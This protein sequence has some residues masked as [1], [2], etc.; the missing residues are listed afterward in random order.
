M[1][2]EDRVVSRLYSRLEKLYG[3]R[4][5]GV[6][7]RLLDVLY[8][9]PMNPHPVPASR[10]DERDIVLITYGDQLRQGD[11]PTLPVLGSFLQETELDRLINTIHIL[12]FYPYSSDDG[13]S[14]IDYRRVDPAIGDWTDVTRLG[15]QT[16]LMFDLVLNHTS[17]ESDWFRAYRAGEEPYTRF[18]I[19]SEPDVDWSQVT[20]PRNTP[21]LTPQQTTR[22]PRY[23]W[24]TFSEDQVDLNFA[25]PE[26]LL[27]FIDILMFYFRQGARIIRLDAIAFLWKQ[28]GTSCIHLPQTHEVVK[29]I[30]DV[31][32]AVAPH[33]ILLTETNVP[34]EEN[35]SYFGA[36]DEAH[37][38]YQFSLP[39]L[40]LDALLNEDAAPLT[41]WLSDF[42]E[43]PGGTTFFNFTASHDGVGVRPLEGLVPHARIERLVEAAK[44]RGG[45]VST[46][47]LAD[48]NESPYELN[49]TYFDA[50]AD[51]DSAPTPSRLRRFLASQ[52]IM[53][54][55]RGI[56]GVYFHSLF[57]TR[58]DHDSVRQ[59]GQSRRINR[60]KFAVDDLMKSLKD[61]GSTTRQVFDAYRHL[62]RSR[63]AQKAFHP[64]GAQ[65]VYQISNDQLL[66]FERSSPDDQ[67]RILVVANLG[68]VRQL[69]D[70]DRL[71]CTARRDLL[72][73]TRLESLQQISLD[74]W[75]VAWLEI[76]GPS[77]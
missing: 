64:D 26:V 25:E 56:P 12:P 47:R 58:N 13:F 76:D 6:T 32:D 38:V 67:Q 45:R 68:S 2:L 69:L 17:R 33:V 57:G 52:A 72:S 28:P 51:L 59:S 14:V 75:Q 9:E 4:A 18:F 1:T 44:A 74:P 61:F 65:R 36:G 3:D 71:G 49:I 55:I 53:L 31:V 16:S 39:P 23:N 7:D 5:A 62:L 73:V 20:R 70:L 27:E 10:W 66:C 43:T 77:K 21:L 63:I 42:P 50:L 60:S 34:H 40:L 30:R 35:I 19:E 15:K 46:R 29:L 37:M 48:G 11:S 54:A 22:G 41:K 24:T 8:R